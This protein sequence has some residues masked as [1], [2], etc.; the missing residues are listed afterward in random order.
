M[1]TQRKQTQRGGSWLYRTRSSKN[2]G[3]QILNQPMCVIQPSGSLEQRGPVVLDFVLRNDP[4]LT[5][6]KGWQL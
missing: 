3:V 6:S 1:L 5:V 4:Y 2:V